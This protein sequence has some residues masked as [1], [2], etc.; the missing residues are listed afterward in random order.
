M[1][2]L[3]QLSKRVLV[4]CSFFLMAAAT[5]AQTLTDSQSFSAMGEDLDPVEIVKSV[6]AGDFTV[7]M[8]QPISSIKILSITVQDT[9]DGYPYPESSWC[10]GDYFRF[11]L[12][13][14]GNLE[15]DEQCLTPFVNYVITGGDEIRI[16]TTDVDDYGDDLEFTVTFE[17]TFAAPAC[18][19]PV[20][21]TTSNLTD[22][23]VTVSWGAGTAETSWIVTWG[24]A[25]FTAG[26]ELGTQTVT[27]TSANIGGLIA[28]TNYEVVIV[29]TCEDESTIEGTILFTT[30]CGA[31]AS[32][33]FCETFE[34]DS[35][36][37]NCWTIIDANN[38]G[39]VSSWFAEYLWC[40][41]SDGYMFNE[42][43]NGV[44]IAGIYN[45]Y[46]FGDNDD[47]LISPAITLTGNDVLQFYSMV[48]DGDEPVSL[49]VL[50]STTGTNPADFTQVLMAETL[51][52]NESWEL[53][54]V[55][56]NGITGTV[57][58]A[59]HVP[60]NSVDGYFLGIDDVC[61][62]T[63][64]P[65][66]AQ[67]GSMTICKGEVE[68]DLSEAITT[69]FVGGT[70]ISNN[71]NQMIDGALLNVTSIASGTYQFGYV[72][73]DL[74]GSDTVFATVKIAD[75][76]NAGQNG[77]INSC[78][79]QYISLVAAIGTDYQATG[80]WYDPNGVVIANPLIQTGTLGGQFL[81]KYV[82]NNGDCP[83]DS[84][85]VTVNILAC[86]ALGID[87]LASSDIQLFPNPTAKQFN[88][89]G[90]PT[91]EDITIDLIDIQG[92][93]VLSTQS[94]QQANV[95]ISVEELMSGVYIVKAIGASTSIQTR[96]IKQ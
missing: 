84:A 38:D 40:L 82:V 75:D 17:V 23:G 88:I 22:D 83:A 12:E 48:Y 27:T 79:N 78:K 87:D 14:D 4:T 70:W 11:S 57:Y 10:D 92:K 35:P 59:F 18:A 42:A 20:G 72:M 34:L 54:S 32:G 41:D 16:F 7:A 1:I 85:T 60:T 43:H 80:V 44:G 68:G 73:S 89:A 5:Q 74:C 56:L 49:E 29:S 47:Y 15:I 55:P 71:F 2:T 52:T 51:V 81:Y 53:V 66:V 39:Y 90:L 13:V 86:D 94:N 30:P 50:V 24:L 96:L 95:S 19:G 3:L 58:I 37:L 65:K 64:Q 45:D 21:I 62:E 67:G 26:Q 6:S 9:Y 91:Y 76:N 63:C 28:S 31:V 25:G 8:G 93:V 69:D 33:S 77:L 61:V 46:S 36:T